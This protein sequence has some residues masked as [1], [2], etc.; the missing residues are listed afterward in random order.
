[1]T[2]YTPPLATAG[3]PAAIDP[4]LLE[5]Q[6]IDTSDE[7]AFDDVA[8][9]AVQACETPIAALTFVDGQRLWVKAQIGL[10][11]IEVPRVAAF[12]D[13]LGLGQQA[14]ALV[15]PDVA[16]DGRFAANPL[17]A[18]PPHVQSYAAAAIMTPD[19][20]HLLGVVEAM[21]LYARSFL[22]SQVEA[23]RALARQAS[24]LLEA[25]RLAASQEAQLRRLRQQ[26]G[27]LNLGIDATL[28]TL[29]AALDQREHE[30]E[31]HLVRVAALTLRL[32]AA[33][34]VPASQQAH[35]RRGALLHDIGKL[36]VP[37][38]ILLK[39]GALNEAEWDIMRLHPLY[40]YEMLAPIALLRPALDIPHAHH[41][42]WN[43]HGYPLGL[44][45]E[46]IPLAA[47]I[48]AVVDVWDALRSERPYRPRWDDAR[49]LDYIVQR[50]GTDF[51]PQVVEA[52]LKLGL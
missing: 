21:D 20:Q 40:A 52:F 2:P 47:R 44:R 5:Y 48:F 45:R 3:G 36:R 10:N 15:I 16:A 6:I 12:C 14:G 33:L 19:G 22:G 11:R 4:V 42:R 37:D 39:P 7:P 9:L 32:A 31:G 38:S 17:V 27:E 18:G 28:A 35:L 23:L 1:M 8:Y 46:A 50:A 51:D 43:G 29:A 30:V 26:N 41:E 24:V 49:T 13:R 25:R 34:G